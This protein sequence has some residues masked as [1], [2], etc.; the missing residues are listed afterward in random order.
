[1][2]LAQCPKGHDST[3]ADFCSECG[4][5]I[6][7]AAAA[8]SQSVTSVPAICPDCSTPHDP[9]AGSFC[10]LCGYNFLT[11]AHGEL[12][13]APALSPTASGASVTPTSDAALPAT[14]GSVATEAPETSSPPAQYWEVVITV[15]PGL[16]SADDPVPPPPQAPLTFRLEKA[17]YLIG[18]HHER[19]GITPDI[20]LDFDDAISHRHALLTC[21]GDGSWCVRDIGSTNGTRRNGMDLEALLDT[22]LQAGDELT[23]GHWTRITVKTV[24]PDSA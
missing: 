21:Q 17:S 15:D 4:A 9:H 13:H 2:P 10:E 12:P 19:R 18:R 7:D 23:L 11:G 16:H 6:V 5:K 3:E 1:M 8:P 24:S 22:P 14:Q 20:A